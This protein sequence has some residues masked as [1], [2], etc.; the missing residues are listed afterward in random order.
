MKRHT[1]PVLTAALGAVLLLGACSNAAGI[2]AL[3]RPATAEDALPESFAVDE[4]DGQTRLLAT[5]DG[6]KYF[7]ARGK[8]AGTACIAAVLETDPK[9]AWA[10]C[11]P[12]S[13]DPVIVTTSGKDGTET[14]LVRDGF[15]SKK[16][17]SEGWTRIH[18]NLLIRGG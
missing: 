3:D 16:L 5:H 14:K 15:D 2:K 6:V 7:G 11:G 13:S 18:D 1:F 17:E 8:D 12:F 10:A 4:F 9:D